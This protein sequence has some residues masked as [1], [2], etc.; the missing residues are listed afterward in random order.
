MSTY[1]MNAIRALGRRNG[2][3][4]RSIA[5]FERARANDS[6]KRYARERAPHRWW[7]SIAQSVRHGDPI[8][9]AGLGQSLPNRTGAR[10]CRN[11][12]RSRSPMNCLFEMTAVTVRGFDWPQTP[13]TLRYKSI[14]VSHTNSIPKKRHF[15][16]RVSIRGVVTQ[17]YPP[18]QCIE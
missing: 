6:P 10:P 15:A 3:R 9:R 7:A 1:S 18:L 12:T 4:R 8:A 16:R 11:S 17:A 2:D 5:R 14:T 13:E